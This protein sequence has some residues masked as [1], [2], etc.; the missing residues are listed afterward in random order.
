MPERL[1]QPRMLKDVSHFFLSDQSGKEGCATYNLPKPA[2]GVVIVDSN[3]IMRF[4]NS[5]ARRML[6]LE[7]ATYLGQLFNF[8]I[9]VNE[10]SEVSIVR[11]N[12]EPGIAS[13][14]IGQAEWC[15]EWQL[16]KKKK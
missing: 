11:E 8:F 10:V 5:I 1:R 9:E 4:A 2:V 14:Q 12:R 7:K 6:G 15:D 13:M 16:A 3:K